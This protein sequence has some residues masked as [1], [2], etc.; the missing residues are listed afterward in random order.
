MP[1]DLSFQS[2]FDYDTLQ[3]GITVPVHMRS[4]NQIAAFEAKVDTGASH[5]IFQRKH[6]ERIG[7]QLESSELIRFNT[8]AGS[9]S[10]FAHDVTL[11]VLNIEVFSK[12][13]F[14]ADEGFPRNVLGRNGWLDRVQLGLIDYDGRLFLSPYEITVH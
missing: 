3:S 5:C 4:G 13:Y 12:V 7:L 8:A 1:I 6:A 2:L 11:T 14:A 10:A 9:F